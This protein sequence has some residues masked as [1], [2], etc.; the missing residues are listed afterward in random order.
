MSNKRVREELEKK[1]KFNGLYDKYKAKA[2]LLLDYQTCR[3]FLKT[4][5]SITDIVYLILKKKYDYPWQDK[6][7]R[8]ATMAARGQRDGEIVIEQFNFREK[9]SDILSKFVKN[10]FN[11]IMRTY[12]ERNY[13]LAVKYLGEEYDELMRNM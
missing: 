5:G 1:A 7:I 2:D 12:Y 6:F 13:P 11:E 10:N 9:I 4:N 8:Q 3:G